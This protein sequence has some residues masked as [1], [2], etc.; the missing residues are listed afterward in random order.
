MLTGIA[1]LILLAQQRRPIGRLARCGAAVAAVLAFAAL[2]SSCGGGGGGGGGGDN[3]NPGTPRGTS[4]VVVTATSA[5]NV[6]HQV[7]ITFTVQ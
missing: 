5:G 3:G 2:M 7:N 4:T 6:N 1:G